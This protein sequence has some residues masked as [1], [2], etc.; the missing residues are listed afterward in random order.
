MASN[1]KELFRECRRLRKDG[2]DGK[3]AGL[4]AE[5]LRRNSLEAE[6]VLHAGRI[7]REIDVEYSGSDQ[8]TVALLGQCTTSWLAPAITAIARGRGYRVRVDEEEYDNVFQG[9]RSLSAATDAVVLLPWSQRLFGDAERTATDRLV[10][11]LD[12]WRRV[13][14]VAGDQIGTRIIQVGYDWLD[15]GAG[16]QHLAAASDGN[17]ALCRELN[18]KLRAELPAGAFFVDLEQVSGVLGRAR[19]YDRRRYYWTKQPFGDE[20]VVQLA[21]H[22]WSGLRSTMIGPKKVL[23]LDLDNT[24]WGGVVGETGASGID[25]GETPSGE[26]FRDFQRLLKGL[27]ERGCI[28]AVCSKNNAQDARAPFTQNPDMILGLDDFAAFEASWDFKADA[29][30]R[31]SES[32]NL[33]LDSF[34]FFDDSAAEREHIR[35]ALPEVEVVDVPDDPADYRQALLSGLWFES[36]AVTAEDRK[37]TRQYRNERMRSE[38]R[39]SAGSIDEYLKSLEMIAHIEPIGDANLNR[40]VQLIG[41]TNQ[42]NLTTRRHP[43]DAVSAL[44]SR[45]DSIGLALRMRDRFGDYGLVSILIATADDGGDASRLRIDTWLMS[46]R[47]IGRTAEQ[48][49]FNELIRQ[50]VSKNCLFLVGD[51]IPSQ[52]NALVADFYEQLG[53]QPCDTSVPGTERFELCIAGATPATTFVAAAAPDR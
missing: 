38:S 6:G 12:F 51:Y 5:A 41:K 10:D 33:G 7:L 36:T 35:Q 26:A 16:G 28:L 25:V 24:L 9:I 22:L 48:F 43:P 50:A 49:L 32:L 39:S 1:P 8:I 31:I 15:T 29:I 30:R 52:K 34:V 45:P 13:W 47:V 53:F 37:R 27:A 17:I 18:A 42:F 4:L 14:S 21:N 2:H 23:V 20:G 3:V 11:E 46:C 44:V 19:F 40:V